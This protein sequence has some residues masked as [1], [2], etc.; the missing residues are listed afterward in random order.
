MLTRRRIIMLS[1]KM[2]QYLRVRL[3]QKFVPLLLQLIP[4]LLVILN[5]PI[6]HQRHPPRLI[7]V[8][9]SV[10]IG[11]LPMRRPARVT[12]SRRTNRRI[13]I[14]QITQTL[15]PPRTLPQSHAPVRSDRQPRRI[16]TPIFQP[17]QP[18]QKNGHRLLIANIANNSAHNEKPVNVLHFPYSVKTHF[19][20]LFRLVRC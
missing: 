19:H 16:I 15:D 9:M 18:I 14:N 7:K 5:H 3:R 6:V 13:R 17:T 12:D 8:W 10:L 2:S 1:N 4:Q 20:F 11:R